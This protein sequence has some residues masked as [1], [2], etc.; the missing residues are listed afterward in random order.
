M[1]KKKILSGIWPEIYD[2]ESAKKAMKH[3]IYACGFIAIVTIGAA[4]SSL[5]GYKFLDIAPEAI[6]DGLLVIF[7]GLGIYRKSRTASILGISFYVIQRLYMWSHHG[8]PKNIVMAIIIMLMF[9]ASVRGTYF[10]HE[11]R[12]SQVLKKNVIILN[13]LALLYSVIIGIAVLFIAYYYFPHKIASLV[14][15]EVV[16]KE[17]FFTIIA[18][19]ALFAYLLTLIRFMPFTKN[20]HVV[21]YSLSEEEAKEFKLYEV[22]YDNEKDPTMVSCTYCDFSQKIEEL[23]EK[24]MICP[25]CK[26]RLEYT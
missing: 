9:I 18:F 19:F 24:E 13:L 12:K 23:L 6:I 2:I 15:G 20:R 22:Y 8:G 7:I 5:Y 26:N 16:F 21:S 14:N 25:N 17:Y 4:F 10:Y 3:G 11:L 1:A